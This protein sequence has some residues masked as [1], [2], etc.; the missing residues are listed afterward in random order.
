M[1]SEAFTPS[2]TRLTSMGP[3][4]SVIGDDY[5][6]EAVYERPTGRRHDGVDVPEFATSGNGNGNDSGS[7]DGSGSGARKEGRAK[8]LPV[9]SGGGP[10]ENA[11]IIKEQHMWGV[12]DTWGEKAGR[13]GKGARAYA[14][15]EE[16]MEAPRQ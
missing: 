9:S 10:R 15:A 12:E 13:W 1:S 14:P 7:G 4:Q 3:D 6:E 16:P 11:P 5:A 2:S 8:G